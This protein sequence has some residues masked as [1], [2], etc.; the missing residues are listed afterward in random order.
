MKAEEEPFLKV[1]VTNNCYLL[2]R[3]EKGPGRKT[4]S[5]LAKLRD[6]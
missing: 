5:D 3:N 1:E 4:P 6:H 2:R